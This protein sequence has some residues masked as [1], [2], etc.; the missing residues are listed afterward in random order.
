M[1]E[2]EPTEILEGANERQEQLD[3]A[4][5]A[6]KVREATEKKRDLEKIRLATFAGIM[7]VLSILSGFPHEHMSEEGLASDIEAGTAWSYYDSTSNKLHLDQFALVLDNSMLENEKANGHDQTL[8]QN[9][10]NYLTAENAKLKHKMEGL[11]AEARTDDDESAQEF[12]LSEIFAMPTLLFSIAIV[13]TSICM[14]WRATWLLW[15]AMVA[16]GLGGAGLIY[17]ALMLVALK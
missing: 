16:A 6:N 1:G 8:L 15:A 17:G 12:K 9:S 5:E 4:A 7:A 10:I 13:L 2:I 3:E 14:I 11:Q